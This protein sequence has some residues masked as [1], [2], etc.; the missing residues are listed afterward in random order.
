MICDGP[1]PCERADC[2]SRDESF[3]PST[4]CAELEAK[5]VFPTCWDGQRLGSE[6]MMV[7]GQARL[8][9]ARLRCEGGNGLI[10]RWTPLQDHVAYDVEEGRFDADCPSSHPVKIPE[11][12]LY[13][14][15]SDYQGGEYTFSDGTSIFHAQPGLSTRVWLNPLS[16]RVRPRV[17]RGETPDA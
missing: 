9:P 1:S 8:A 4:A 16:I 14:R 2:S 12:H 13:F 7:C 17:A 3:F 5:L 10:S 11:I 6:N 15:I